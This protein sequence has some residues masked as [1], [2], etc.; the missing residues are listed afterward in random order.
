MKGG[1]VVAPQPEAVEAGALVLK[2]GGNAVDAAMTCALVQTVVDPMMCGIAGFGTLQLFLPKKGY[3]GFIDFHTTAPAAAT[4]DMW[5]DKIESQS[6]DG[7][8]FILTDRAN[9]AGYESIMTPGSLKAYYEAVEEFG[10]L[11]WQDIV[12]PAIDYA[13]EGFTVRPHVDEFWHASN[14][15]GRMATVDKLKQV[16]AARKIYFDEEGNTYPVGARVKNPDMKRT[17]ERIRDGGAD[18]F[19]SGDLGEEII[20]DVK[21]NGGFLSLEDLKS[22]KTVRNKPVWGQYR[23]YRV[24][25]NQPPGGGVTVVEMLQILEHFDLAAMGHNS[26]D[27]IATVAEAMKW[28]TIDKDQHI[29]DPAFVDVPVDILTSKAHAAAYADRIKAGEKANVVRYGQP[30]EVKDTTHLCVVDGD[31]NAVSMTH[32]LGMP[33]GVVSE[34]F[35]F[36]YNGCMGAFD[37]RPG[38]PGSIAPGKR[39]FTAMSPTIVFDGDDPYIV[40]GAP[41]GTFITMGILQAILNVVDFGMSMFEAVAAP[42]ITANSNTIDVSNRIPRFITDELEGRGY[43]VARSPFSFVFAGVHGVRI[44]NGK[45]D[46]GADPGRDGMSLA[47]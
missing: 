27:Y 24:A 19:Y 8:G 18:V 20:V 44:K 12:Q 6:R 32:S 15:M 9:E 2:R 7:F 29:G 14:V 13:E 23:G 1:M 33:S 34:G 4:E 45:M 5:Q 38:Y 41:G 40:V 36:M 39:R 42:R 26:A 37:P 17:L 46:G 43:P 11:E 22:Y 16:E 25:S 35:G 30:T 21:R 10:T 3:H 28:A 31:G 47:V